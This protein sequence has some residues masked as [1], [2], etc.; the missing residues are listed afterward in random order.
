M[1]HAG[2]YFRNKAHL[3]KMIKQHSGVYNIR[4]PLTDEQIYQDIIVDDTLDTFSSYYP[5]IYVLPANLNQLR[6]PN[7]RESTTDAVSD[8]YEL[9]NLSPLTEGNK[10]HSIAKIVPFNAMGY[11]SATYAYETIDAFQALGISQ[12]VANLASL[13]EPPMTFE[14]LG[15]RRFRLRNGTYY[16]SHVIIYVEMSYHPE[17]YDIPPGYRVA[18]AGLAE[19]DFRRTMYSNLKYWNELRSAAAEYNLRIDDWQN[20]E[21]ERNGMLNEWDQNFH[22][23]RVG[24]IQIF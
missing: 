13:I 2:F 1:A 11:E 5:K 16:R 7:A 6:V 19:L 9:P 21:E 8:I 17:L 20:A 4:L 10:I 3:I 12:G 18:F 24:T 14:Y 23:E 15:G 22:L